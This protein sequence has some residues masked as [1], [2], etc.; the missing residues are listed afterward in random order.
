LLF[1]NIETYTYQRVAQDKNKHR[2]TAGGRDDRKRRLPFGVKS[3]PVDTPEIVAVFCAAFFLGRAVLLGDLFPFGTSFIAASVLVFSRF[4]VPAAAGVILG[5]ITVSEGAPLASS[6]VTVLGTWILAGLVPVDIKR[7]WLVLPALVL[8]VTMV[9]KASFT[10]FTTPSDY[11]Y[12]AVLFEAVFAAA[13]TPVMIYGFSA[14]KRKAKNFIAFSGEEVCCILLIL[15]GVIAGTGDLEFGVV[16][17]KGVLSRLAILTAAFMGGTGTGAAAG[18]VV[19]I[20]PGLAY[21]AAPAIVGVYSF[22]GLLAGAG[23]SF[24]KAGV[25]VGFVLGNIILSVYVNGR[26]DIVSPLVE[27]GIAA[28]IFLMLPSSLVEKLKVSLGLS[29]EKAVA[30]PDRGLIFKEIFEHRIKV[31]SHVFKEMSRTFEQV[32]STTGQCQEERSLQAF[33]NQVG[34]KVCSDCSFYKICWERE[35]YKTYQGL[36]DIL[37]FIEMNG[38]VTSDNLSGEI[39]KRCSRTK[40]FAI[41]INCLYEAYNLN[42]Y[43]SRRLL[44]SREIVSE[45]LKGVSEVI[46][47]LPGELDFA[48]EA[49]E[50]GPR[51]RKKLKEAGAQVEGLSVYRREDGGIEISLSHAPC[52]GRKEC[53]NIVVPLLASMLDQPVYLPANACTAREGDD[54][55]HLRFYPHLKYRLSLGTAVMGKTGSYISGDGHAFFHLKG[56]RMGLV[57]SDGMGT[58]PRAALESGTTISLLRYLLESG[59]GQELAIKTVNSILLLR[60]PGES[61]ATVDLAV[62]NL[63]SGR[64]DFVKIGAVPTFVLHDGEVNC[65]KASSLPV[66]I[67]EDVEVTSLNG[68]LE[69]E[70]VLVMVTDGVLDAY[71]GA[72]DREEW[73]ARTLLEVKDLPPRD[74]A[75][76]ILKLVQTGAGGASRVKDDM[77]VVVAR[78]KKQKQVPKKTG[79][80]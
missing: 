17:I 22:A 23:R 27:T 41:T 53:R 64:V 30:P 21:A 14:F 42:R 44:E 69:P 63:Y 66:G 16:S 20:I 47:N 37:A 13:L 4:G 51:L 12:F 65:I 3:G 80:I 35:F 46:A 25:A 68:T 40:E 59:F 36:I 61:F 29:T 54:Y 31:W 79:L 74:M 18:A 52:G 56:G 45:Q 76:L 77:T 8:S 70:D 10:A 71:R 7:P 5:L 43:W 24:G 72:E 34:E 67:I 33:L 49:G 58:G 19:G 48:L 57:L 1:E 9:V 11:N 50:A 55:C 15:G 78:L 75:E 73:F 26:E 39:K 38:K 6:V 28:A 62:V 2:R 60:S 32:S